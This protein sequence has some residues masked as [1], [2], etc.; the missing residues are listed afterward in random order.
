VQTPR[1]Y[2][3]T[4]F[5]I[6]HPSG[7]EAGIHS[8]PIDV[9]SSVSLPLKKWWG[10]IKNNFNGQCPK[11]GPTTGVILGGLRRQLGAI[12]FDSHGAQYFNP[13]VSPEPTQLQSISSSQTHRPPPG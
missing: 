10:D 12:L 3:A 1:F 9:S 11:N 7:G 8:A 5:Q 13:E 4:E 2:A 6:P